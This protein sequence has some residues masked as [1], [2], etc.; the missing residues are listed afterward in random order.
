ML[1]LTG[2]AMPVDLNPQATIAGAVNTAALGIS[3]VFAM[4]AMK[5]N[6]DGLNKKHGIV[7]LGLYAAYTAANFI[8]GGAGA[9]AAATA[10]TSAP[11]APPPPAPGLR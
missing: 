1:S 7:A 10:A 4:A 6:K 3:T 5:W 11:A 9:D 2:A 8:F